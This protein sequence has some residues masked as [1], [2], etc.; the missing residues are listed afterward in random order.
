[1]TDGTAATLRA[2]VVGTGFGC[3]VQVPALMAAGFDVVGLVGADAERTAKRAAMNGVP[4]AFTDL[5][6]AITRTGANVVAISVPPDVHAEVTLQAI[7]HGC[8]VLCEKPFA[9]NTVEAQSMLDAIARTGK[10]HALGHE[11]RYLPH[12]AALQ[13]AIAD[14]LIGEPRLA[15]FVQHSSWVT[16]S[17]PGL[18]DWW[19]D[20]A[21]GG[22]WLGAHSPHTLDM[23]R[24]WLGDFETVSAL[25][26]RVT[27]TRGEVEDSY[28]MRFRM[29]NG[30]VGV[31]QQCGGDYAGMTEMARIVGSKG[32]VWIE[33]TRI[34]FADRDG[35][36]EIPIGAE[37]ELPPMPPIPDDP[38]QK[39]AEWDMLRSIEL[40]PY[41]QLGRTMRAAI[42]GEEPPTR[43]PMATFRDGVASIK[44]ADAIR[45]SACEDGRLTAV[46]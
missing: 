2:L 5:D 7:G 14:G 29:K 3:R 21:Q 46:E 17:E 22:G 41:I 36:R 44:L 13:A 9:A 26:P 4:E 31:I 10:V 11:F 12:R 39:S 38:R 28:S 25:L 45:A 42:L 8:H 24:C 40:Q 30:A 43:I 15:T 18:M 33:G 32:A 23:I 35:K 37:F 27:L 1:M 16:E 34:L 20:P 6:R 19:F